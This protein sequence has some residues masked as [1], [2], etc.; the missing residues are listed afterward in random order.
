[1]KKKIILILLLMRVLCL[2]ADNKFYVKKIVIK[3]L[4]KTKEKTFLKI[5]GIKL[6]QEWNKE[7]KKRC[8]RRLNN[9]KSFV[10]VKI[11]EEKEGKSI[12]LYI[13]AKD[14]WSII[15]FPMFSFGEDSSFGG[16]IAQTNLLGRQQLLLF[17]LLKQYGALNYRGVFVDPNFINRR[18]QFIISGGRSKNKIEEFYRDTKFVN[19]LIG[20]RMSEHTILSLAYHFSNYKFSEYLDNLIL[21]DGNSHAIGLTFEYDKR[22][23]LDDYTKGFYLKSVIKRELPCSEFSITRFI[24]NYE[25]YINILKNHT[26]LI[27]NSFC[28]SSKSQRGQ[29]Y[30]LGGFGGEF[31]LPLK[32]YE[33]YA[34]SYGNVIS[35]TAEYRVPFIQGKSFFLSA[36]A[37]YDYAFASDKTERILNS[38]FYSSAGVSLRLYLKNIMVPA[39]QFF[40]AYNFELK[41]F[42]IGVSVGMGSN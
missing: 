33:N 28:L 7:I 23:I 12:N 35:G 14:K 1:M 3:G 31:T 6:G 15:P 27:S 22:N 21:V 11:S 4:N 25:N 5:A 32:S 40:Y 37:F 19:S 8:L 26:L 30:L 29:G 13:S 39:F 42:K 41:K 2:S 16:A 20:Y 18:W 34:Y 24:V 10:D 17:T 36:V 9:R 38:S